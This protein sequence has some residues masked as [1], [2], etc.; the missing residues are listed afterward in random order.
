MSTISPR[1]GLNFFR[2]QYPYMDTYWIIILMIVNFHILKTPKTFFY[3]STQPPSSC[4]HNILRYINT[5]TSRNE[6][7]KGGEE[8][9]QF[10]QFY[11]LRKVH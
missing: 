11:C 1:L 5:Y 3:P 10:Y 9:R 4:C 6:G 7:V 2:C 8:D